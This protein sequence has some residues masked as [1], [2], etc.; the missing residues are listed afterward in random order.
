M[1]APYL[2]E[3]NKHG[4][5]N[6]GYISVAENSNLPFDVKRI[7]WT[8]FTPES[9]IR[10]RH[11]HFQTEQILFAA[12]G[13]IIIT[14]EN[15]YG[16]IETFKL[17]EPNFGLYIPPNIWHTMQYSHNAIQLVFASTIFDEKDYIR[18]YSDFLTAWKK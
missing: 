4:Q 5:P 11:A 17:E 2:I 14:T 12:A 6:I 13:R 9:I 8:Y 16:T 7:F 15:A 10:G 1:K 3:F 18:S